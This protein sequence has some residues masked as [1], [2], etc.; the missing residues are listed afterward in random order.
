M[1]NLLLKQNLL[2]LPL[3]PILL[4]SLSLIPIACQSIDLYRFERQMIDADVTGAFDLSL[5]DIDG[6][7]LVDIVAVANDPAQFVWYQNP[8]WN[9]HIIS[10]SARGN[11]ATA[12][13]DIDGD[14]DTDL[15][16]ASALETNAGAQ[17]GLLQ[18]FENPGNPEEV[19]QWSEHTISRTTAPQAV[20]WIDVV[21][22]ARKILVSLPQRDG[23]LRGY[24]IPRNPTSN[25][26][27]VVLGQASA[28]THG[29][30]VSDYNED[31]KDELLI[32]SVSGVDMVQFATE[33]QSVLTSRIGEGYEGI[34]PNSGSAKALLGRLSNAQRFI[35]SIEP[36]NGN[37]VVIYTPSNN[38]D[39][40]W[41][42]AVIDSSLLALQAMA[43][44]DSNNDGVD[45]IV[46]ANSAQPYG[47]YTYRFNTQSGQWERETLSQVSTAIADID[48]G[49]V[50]GDGRS[51][52]I[53]AGRSGDIILLRSAQ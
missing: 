48:V 5:A 35:A 6:D 11:V 19:Q 53:A 30:A 52:I 2:H 38:N 18:W 46:V 32:A 13:Y 47:I 10:S 14:G 23:Q 9:K 33:E 36:W 37:E 16:L 45:E 21:G 49:D 26:Q 39:M 44:V 7:G 50:N 41:E 29:L 4:L 43:L 3:K 17:E 8:S 27:S 22:N 34:A 40:T 42:R 51:D 24:P 28:R 20:Q 12:P 15:V 31:G 25:W 1:K